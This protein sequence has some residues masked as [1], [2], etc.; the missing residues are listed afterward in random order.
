MYIWYYSK[1][2]ISIIYLLTY[3]QG[4]VDYKTIK[5]K[6]R[7]REVGKED[8]KTLVSVKQWQIKSDNE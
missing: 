3:R 2:T 7:A 6:E 1:Q 4:Q 5:L 8:F